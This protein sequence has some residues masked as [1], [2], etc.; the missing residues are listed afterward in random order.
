MPRFPPK[1]GGIV[2]FHSVVWPCWTAKNPFH[3]LVRTSFSISN[4]RVHGVNPR[5]SDKPKFHRVLL[6]EY[7]IIYLQPHDIPIKIFPSDGLPLPSRRRLASTSTCHFGMVG[8]QHE[9]AESCTC[10]Q[11]LHGIASFATGLTGYPKC[12]W[13]GFRVSPLSGTKIKLQKRCAWQRKKTKWP[14]NHGWSSFSPLSLNFM[15]IPVY[16]YTG[17]PLL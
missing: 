13:C 5:S 6:V 9:L 3:P 12:R 2:L 4:C 7:P 10:I 17:I 16:Q 15:G 11:W 14:K 1:I 8:D